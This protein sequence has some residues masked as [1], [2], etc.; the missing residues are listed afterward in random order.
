MLWLVDA[1]FAAAGKDKGR[2]FSPAL[3]GYL[4]DVHLLRFEIFHGRRDVIAQKIKLVLVVL[5]GI[6][7]RGLEW[8]H[9]EDQPAMAGINRGKLKHIAKES[10]VSFRI[11]GVDYDMC[12]VDQA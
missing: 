10:S 6:V 12:A 7:E 2:K 1:Y 4:R 8:R 3:F 11:P 5:L 9:G